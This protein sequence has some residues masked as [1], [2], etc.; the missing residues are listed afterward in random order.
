[1]QREHVKHAKATPIL[2]RA[3]S[4]MGIARNNQPKT[5]RLH[6]ARQILMHLSALFYLS[7]TRNRQDEL[8]FSYRKFSLWVSKKIKNKYN[9]NT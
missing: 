7:E 5:E 3:T 4:K 1:M 6:Y 2:P 9:R 8:Q